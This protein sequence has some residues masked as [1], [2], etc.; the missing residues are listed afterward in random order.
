MT[1]I[2]TPTITQDSSNGQTKFQAFIDPLLMAGNGD[3]GADYKRMA[4][5]N[6][7]RGHFGL[8]GIQY[9]ESCLEMTLDVLVAYGGAAAVGHVVSSLSVTSVATEAVAAG[10]GGVQANRI[11]GQVG[12]D[13]LARTYGGSQQTGL[14]TSLGRRVIDNLT[15]TGI[16]QE[17]KVGLTSLTSREQ[18]QLAKDTELL[19][20]GAV[21][22]VE[23]HFFGSSTGLG[24][25]GPL[26]QALSNAGFSIIKH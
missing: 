3:F 17:S 21:N 25:T 1:T 5:S 11:A 4:D 26:Q 2:D 15:S 13:F 22:G 14:P 18:T 23:W 16:A 12:E 9:V 7:Q 19:S 6:L 10:K 8:A 24:P 20:S